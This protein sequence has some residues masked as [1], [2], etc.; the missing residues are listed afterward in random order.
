MKLYK[1]L[2]AITALFFLTGSSL[3]AQNYTYRGELPGDNLNLF[4]VMKLFQDCETLEEFEFRIN[5]MHTGINNLDLNRDRRVDYISVID[6]NN[7]D[8]HN[9]VLRANTGRRS[10]ADVAVFNIVMDGRDRVYIQL[11]G[12][13]RIYGE[14]YIVEPIYDDYSVA[15]GRLTIGKLSVVVSKTSPFRVWNWPIIRHI[16]APDYLVW[17]SPWRWNYYPGGWSAWRPYSLDYYYRYQREWN[18]Y[19]RTYDRRWNNY[20]Y[21]KYI[22][23]KSDNYR[24]NNRYKYDRDDRYDR[25]DNDRRDDYRWDNRRNNDNRNNSG[26]SYR[27]ESQRDKGNTTQQNREVKRREEK[28]DDNKGNTTQQRR[29]IKHVAKPQKEEYKSGS[30]YRR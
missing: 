10:Y 6:Y 11:I 12:D 27:R 2:F 20:R 18:D 21:P 8:V 15:H 7:G 4:A 14:N 25:R 5:D 24:N 22:Y 29:D 13:E 19:Y 28:R 30:A 23:H 1:Y 26:S 16:F 17:T 9:I 3:S